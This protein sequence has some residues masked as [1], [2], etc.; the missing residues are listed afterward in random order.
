LR[1]PFGR[2]FGKNFQLALEM[3][4]HEVRD[5]IETGLKN[6]LLEENFYGYSIRSVI[7]SKS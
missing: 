5:I 1:I 2:I 4:I 7:T 3:P 6:R